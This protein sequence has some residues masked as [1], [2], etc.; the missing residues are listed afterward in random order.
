MKIK[1]LLLIFNPFNKREC[2]FDDLVAK[3]A[4]R[5]RMRKERVSSIDFIGRKIEISSFQPIYF[6]K[7]FELNLRP[8]YL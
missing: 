2:K 7:T 5:Y 6:K 1:M 4:I 3:F 8:R